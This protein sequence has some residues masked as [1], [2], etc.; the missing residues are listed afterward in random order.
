[1]DQKTVMDTLPNGSE[2]VDGQRA[3]SGAVMEWPSVIASKIRSPV[4]A[5]RC[6]TR[7]DKIVGGNWRMHWHRAQHVGQTVHFLLRLAHT[8]RSFFY[9]LSLRAEFGKFERTTLWASSAS[10]AWVQS[11]AAWRDFSAASSASRACSLSL[12]ALAAWRVR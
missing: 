10:R 5:C 11:L 4:G 2:H 8:L 7:E 3:C 6:C 9:F 1:M 12:A